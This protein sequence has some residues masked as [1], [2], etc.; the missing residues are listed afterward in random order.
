MLM[1]NAQNPIIFADIPDL[2]MIRVVDT[3]YMASPTMLL[4]PGVPVIKS[5]DLV[6]R[7]MLSYAYEILGK[8]D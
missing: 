2:W 1:Q 5:K 8:M 6:N 4:C 7:E 3:Y